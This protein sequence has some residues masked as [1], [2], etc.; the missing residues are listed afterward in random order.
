M[1]KTKT[2]PPRG[3]GAWALEWDKLIEKARKTP[4]EWNVTVD[5][6]PK[7]YY[8]ALGQKREAPFVTEDGRLRFATRN[9]YVTREG[10]KMCTLWLMWEPEEDAA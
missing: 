9:N 10:V 5:D 2:L 6:V 7:S 8:T 4:G 1:A 3:A